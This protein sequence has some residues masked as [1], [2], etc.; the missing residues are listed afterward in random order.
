MAQC[1]DNL[2]ASEAELIYGYSTA[3]WVVALIVTPLISAFGIIF[4]VA[5]MFVVYKISYM[6]TVTNVFL[7]SLA[8]ADSSLLS[9]TVITNIWSFVVSPKYNPAD[10]FDTIFGC[11]MSGFSVYLCYYASLWTI[12]MVSIERFIAVCHPLLY[13]RISSK[14]RAFRI[15]LG[16]WL[17]SA[18]FASFS[19][20]SSIIWVCVVSPDGLIEEHVVF[21]SASCDVC[22]K[23]LCITDIVQSVLSL[24]INIAMYTLIL[25]ELHKSPM[26]SIQSTDRATHVRN[27]V[28]RMLMINGVVFFVCLFPYTV[29]NVY[30]I[31]ELFDWIIPKG[32]WID[33]YKHL[34][35]ILYLS[36]SALNPL[37]YNVTNAR[38]RSAF[39]E[40]FGFR[41]ED[42]ATHTYSLVL[43]S[44][45]NRSRSPSSDD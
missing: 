29:V 9:F 12:T 14:R 44:S 25:V 42:G 30:Y 35:T 43:G 36:N 28:A 27:A 18:V 3:D 2:T 15:T 38:Y 32:N 4:N 16:A 41:K 23:L 13:R 40:A 19:A 17:A 6:R 21:C 37:I 10:S 45:P 31:S 1:Y 11:F 20:P 26:S 8:I 33:V 22:L 5:I 7:V 39:K 24:I 34:A